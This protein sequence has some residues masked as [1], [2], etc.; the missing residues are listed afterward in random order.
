MTRTPA[1]C[2]LYCLTILPAAAQIPTHPPLKRDFA[3]DSTISAA[4]AQIP[5]HTM[6]GPN[7]GNG[8]VVYG[9]LSLEPGALQSGIASWLNS[10]FD[11]T[12][13]GDIQT[14]AAVP[15]KTWW[16]DYVDFT[17]IYPYQMWDLQET[18]ASNGFVM[19]SMLLHATADMHVDSNAGAQWINMQQ[20]DAFEPR[21]GGVLANGVFLSDG[22]SYVDVTNQSWYGSP[23]TTVSSMLYVGYMEPFDQMNFVVHTGRVGG[24]VSYQYWSGSNWQALPIK[25]DSS[26]GLATSGRVYFYPPSR[27]K[28]TSV[29]G[30]KPKF[31]I[32]VV[33][34]SASTPPAYTTVTGDDWSVASPG[35][36]LR[37][38]STSYNTRRINIGTRLE[39]DPT[40]P[41]NATA[42]FRYQARMSNIN[43][44]TFGNPSDIQNNVRTWGQYLSDMADARILPGT[45][46]VMFDD[47]GAEPSRVTSPANFLA[48]TDFN[49]A[50]TWL[51]EVNATYA[52]VVAGLHA[53]HGMTVP[54]VSSFQVG[55]NGYLGPGDWALCEGWWCHVSTNA[56]ANAISAYDLNGSTLTYD[57]ALPANNPNNGKVIMT[58]VDPFREW[59]SGELFTSWHYLDLANRT[60]IECLAM[61]YLGW[62]PNT[63]FGYN[64]LGYYYSTTDEVD[65]YAPATTLT[66][67][68]QA[69]TS[70]NAKTISLADASGCNTTVEWASGKYGLRLGTPA[71]GDTVSGTLAGNTF[72]T[73]DPIYAAYPAGS[74]ASCIQLKHLSTIP[75]PPVSNVYK[76]VNWFPARAVDIGTPDPYGYRGGA[77]AVTEPGNTPWKKGG[78]P[79]YIS[80]QPRATCDAHPGG[81]ADVWRRDFT[82]AIVLLR[83]W[84]YSMIESEVDTPS[85]PIPLGGTY[86]PL[87]AD[88][89]T[90]PGITSV[91]LR[92]NEGAILMKAPNPAVY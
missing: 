30:S 47:Y 38:W 73:K 4:A 1:L 49:Q 80:G 67:G 42:K 8:I 28:Q 70:A 19:E 33:V 48:Y 55:T 41:P 15:T 71:F 5:T 66:N 84:N 76:W 81:C 52:S 12:I 31:W 39:Y 7:N 51:A 44:T 86:Y 16:P 78:A 29:N 54:G 37:G 21:V 22:T 58:C 72:T 69:D 26:D 45:D 91:T 82:N 79:D 53:E 10:H 92:G 18:A 65:V 17:Y 63:L 89:T 64:T 25:S 61:H 40:P 83:A 36:N 13:G 87:K 27:W 35:N 68:V 90:G 57:L 43:N 14:N 56:S 11:W 9:A 50:S 24:S 59:A 88:G 2:A 85:Q 3:Q 34:S 60:P 75:N 20:F 62:N 77:R 46:G 23:M 74:P 6:H 32:R